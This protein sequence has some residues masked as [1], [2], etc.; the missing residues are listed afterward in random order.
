MKLRAATAISL[1]L[2]AAASAYANEATSSS[3][4]DARSAASNEPSDSITISRH[5][6]LAS[7]AAEP[8]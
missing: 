3:R 8:G 6:T 5:A 4:S 1:F 2:L 7:A